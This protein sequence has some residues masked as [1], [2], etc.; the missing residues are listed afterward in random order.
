M[1]PTASVRSRFPA[2]LAAASAARRFVRDALHGWGAGEAVDDAVLL[3]SELVTNAVVHAG[4]SVEVICQL[5]GSA[6]QVDVVDGAPARKLPATDQTMVGDW[7]RTNGRGLLLPSELAGIWGVTYGTE[8][9]TVWFRLELR[10]ADPAASSDPPAPL[11][12]SGPDGPAGPSGPPASADPAD[13][14]DPAGQSGQVELFDPSSGPFDPFHRSDR[15]GA[16]AELLAPAPFRAVNGVPVPLGR[17]R[18]AHLAQLAQPAG[19]SRTQRGWLGFLAEASDLLA[20]TF[21]EEMLVALSAQ[22]VVPRLAR[23]CAFRLSEPPG[24]PGP[25]GPPGDS[26]EWRLAHVWHADEQRMGGLRRLLE[27]PG[28]L[29]R[30]EA[31]SKAWPT[32]QQRADA[33]FAAVDDT[34]S[35]IALPLAARG[36]RLGLLI[37]GRAEDAG[38]AGDIRWLVED[39]GRR[40]ALCLDN[41]RMYSR[42]LAV[43][44]ALQRG[45]L[46]PDTP[47]IPGIDHSVLYEPA[48]EGHDVGGDFYDIFPVSGG[49]WRFAL[50]DVCGIGPEAAAVTGLA[51]HTLRLLARED[52]GVAAVLDRLNE[53]LF[54]E[55]PRARLITV[56]HGELAPRPGGGAALT[57]AAA[58][59]PLPLLLSSATGRVVAAAT[60]QLLLGA[61]AGIRYYEEKFDLAVGDVLLCVTDG[62]TE[63]R[64]DGRLLDDDD[65]LAR[66]LSDCGG[67]TAAAVA[68]RLRRA[69][70]EFAPTPSTD[71]VAMLVLRVRQPERH[72]SLVSSR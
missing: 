13:P 55:G 1:H 44:R 4:T 60:P 70:Q 51:R 43:S 17:D 10:A 41:A 30:D 6:I 65:G 9:K 14:A 34:R 37:L 5:A 63:R 59:H 62:V 15:L 58:G 7:M 61:L 3:T 52:Y 26:G 50:G 54:E 27:R 24:P 28:V 18:P 71:D 38:Y 42:Q 45:L 39:M 72:P 23:W 32:P 40:I 49:R 31:G 53:A 46:P 69:V 64:L 8:T 12:P 47:I 20:G 29:G 16:P 66:L 25:T 33:D 35:V 2:N 48:G 19:L 11:R 68:A 57:V 56:L 67:L 36:R 22:L 21:D